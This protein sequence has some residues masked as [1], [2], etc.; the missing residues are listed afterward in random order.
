MKKKKILITGGAGFVGSQLGYKLHQKGHEVILLDDMSFGNVDN[1]LIDGNS[2]GKLVVADITSPIDHSNLRN[3][4]LAQHFDKVDVVFHLAGVAALPVCQTNPQRALSVNIAGVANILEI[5]R[6][7]NIE[8]FIFSSTS[9]VYENNPDEILHENL[10]VNPDLL[11]SSSKYMAEQVCRNYSKNYGM[12][13]V[14]A[15]FFNLYGP[16]QDFKRASPPFTSYVAREIVNNRSPVIFNKT[17]AKRDYVYI[18][19]CLD[20]LIKMMSSEKKYKSDI[21]NIG[22]G[23]GHSTPEILESMIT[24]SGKSIKPIFNEAIGY[25]DSYPELFLG[26]YTLSKERIE[27]E[28]YKNAIADIKKTQS[29]FDWSPKVSI[30]EGLKNVLNYAM[31]QINA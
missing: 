20:L 13:I 29:E 14:I 15:R 11:Y 19:D 22:T 5:C 26:D 4:T 17:Q 3:S 6:L 27:K 25:W 7:K 24:I 12:N 21:F 8:K 9:A 1:L 30:K 31:G 28:V 18:D 2:F 23:T 16:H 10:V